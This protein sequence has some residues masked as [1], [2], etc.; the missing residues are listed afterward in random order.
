MITIVNTPKRKL[1]PP[2]PLPKI[3]EDM[4]RKLTED[5]WHGIALGITIGAGGIV[6]V[7]AG[8]GRI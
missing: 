4:A 5:F 1:A 7:L 3:T 8:I 6:A 2:E